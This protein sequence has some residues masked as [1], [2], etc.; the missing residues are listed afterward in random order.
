MRWRV[1]FYFLSALAADLVSSLLS[2]KNAVEYVP[3]D[4]F[5]TNIIESKNHGIVW[6]GR[7]LKDHLTPNPLP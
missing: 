4:R 5:C 6:I 3:F 7:S 1:L 2:P